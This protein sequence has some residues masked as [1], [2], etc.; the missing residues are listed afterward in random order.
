VLS[1]IGIAVKN[2][3][4]AIKTY[5]LLLGCEPAHI[6]EVS[7]QQVRVA[8]FELGDQPA[9][10]PPRIELLEPTSDS[11]PIARFL[12][13]RGEGLHHI[14]TYVEDI[15]A[16]L[17]DLTAA[18]NRLIDQKPRIGAEGN[19]I[20]FVHPASFNGVLIELEEKPK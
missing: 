14:C 13:K 7:D 17:Q 2:L 8:M 5:R 10:H 18:G 15:E 12:D 9:G 19:R 1:H 4:Q 20:A 3:D 16:A 11:S 6:V